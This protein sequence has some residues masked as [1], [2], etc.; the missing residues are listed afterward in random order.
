M[1]ILP[2]LQHSKASLKAD[3]Y[4]EYPMNVSKVFI[5]GT[6][7]QKA[8]KANDKASAP[9]TIVQPIDFKFEERDVDSN[10]YCFFTRTNARSNTHSSTKNK[11]IHS[12]QLQK[13][14]LVKKLITSAPKL[15]QQKTPMQTEI[16][17][18]KLF[19][20][21]DMLNHQ[22]RKSPVQQNFMLTLTDKISAFF[23]KPMTSLFK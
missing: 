7:A 18:I 2:Y 21:D 10:L 1:V 19:E 6:K 3:Y 8:Q 12:N 23:S 4:L 22:K 16:T 14:T 13:P 15:N 11:G 17:I 20:Q 9:S 5:N